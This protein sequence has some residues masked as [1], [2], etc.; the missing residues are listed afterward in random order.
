MTAL[1]RNYSAGR[2]L[3]VSVLDEAVDQSAFQ[4][5][6]RAVLESCPSLRQAITGAGGADRFQ[7]EGGVIEDRLHAVAVNGTEGVDLAAVGRDALDDCYALGDRLFA[8]R[9]I[10]VGQS[11]VGML[12]RARHSLVDGRSM[13]EIVRR[14]MA[15]LGSDSSGAAGCKP[16]EH[17]PAVESLLPDRLQ[18]PA[19]QPLL[20]EFV[21]RAEAAHADEPD[22]RACV[23][24][25][26]GPKPPSAGATVATLGEASTEAVQAVARRLDVSLSALLQAAVLYAAH[27][28][29]GVHATH[30]A[31]VVTS[32][33]L[34]RWLGVEA[35]QQIG[36]L[37]SG[38]QTSVRVDSHE[39]L[40]AL[41]ARMNAELHCQRAHQDAM[42]ATHLQLAACDYYQSPEGGP[43]S[44]WFSHLGRLSVP[45][46]A[47]MHGFYPVFRLGPAVYWHTMVCNGRLCVSLSYDQHALSLVRAQ[48]WLDAV[49]SLLTDEQA[50]RAGPQAA[51][52]AV[53]V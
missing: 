12:L 45:G 36:M 53:N 14:L 26:P 50:G 29:C 40:A 16:L 49:L 41:A 43:G 32:V 3:R 25:R 52:G 19:A 31:D 7:T 17:A 46:V 13:T 47:R 18:L 33:D 11:C 38:F 35:D 24:R 6:Y 5:A 28:L 34:R 51:Q 20:E 10:M 42:L 2:I 30:R 15:S 21:A 22:L 8:V 37:S 44:V 27:R 1:D 9:P 4:D 39:E 23:L 48:R